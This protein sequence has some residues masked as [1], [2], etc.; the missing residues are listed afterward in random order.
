MS[1]FEPLKRFLETCPPGERR[2]SFKEVERVL[3]FDLPA[4]ARRHRPWWSN[5]PS[6]ISQAW[7]SA[8]CRTEQVDMAGETLVFRKSVD[9][10]AATE[11]RNVPS[12]TP[13]RRDLYGALEG[14]V[15]IAPG[16]DI[17]EP[18]GEVW[19]ADQGPL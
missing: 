5:D 6:A 13:P 4:A 15:R 16:V 19:A 8:G 9:G 10:P 18:T 2:M 11:G 3:G 1:R 12:E 17:T 14:T 7:L